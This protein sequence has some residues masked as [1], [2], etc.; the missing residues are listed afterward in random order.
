MAC[1]FGKATSGEA[2]SN[3]VNGCLRRAI[4]NMCTTKAMLF[5]KSGFESKRHPFS[6]KSV[7]HNGLDVFVAQVHFIHISLLNRPMSAVYIVL[8]SNLHYHAN[9]NVC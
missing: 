3:N 2:G 7:Y 6:Q 5:F 9:Q 8:V 1:D 4:K